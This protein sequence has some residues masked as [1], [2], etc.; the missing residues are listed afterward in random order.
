M[1]VGYKYLSL[2]KSEWDIETTNIFRDVFLMKAFKQINPEI[3][4]DA[5]LKDRLRRY[6]F[7][8]GQ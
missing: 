4:E 7:N 8:V 6:F 2:A 3:V 5:D 1:Q